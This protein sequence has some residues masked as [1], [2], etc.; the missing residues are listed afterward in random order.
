ME[1][2]KLGIVGA[3]AIGQFNAQEAAQSGVVEIVGVFDTNQK[4]ARSVARKLS[5]PVCA[6][7]EALLAQPN[8][9]AVLLS[10]PHHLHR[11]MTLTAAALGKHILL[12]KPF[13]TTLEEAREIVEGCRRHQV[14]L[15]VNFSL[16][17]LPK[18]RKAKELL[19]QGVVGDIAGFQVVAHA[20][21][22][23][24]YWLGGRSNSPDDWRGSREKAGAGVLFMNVCHAIDYMNMLTGLK[25]SRVYSEYGTLASPAEVEDSASVVCRLSN[26]AIGVINASTIMR[27][28]TQLEER[29]WGQNG[30]LILTPTDLSFYST[31][32]IDGKVP[33]KW[34]TL[35]K[36][37]SVSWTGE[38]VKAFVQALRE[39]REPEVSVRAGW[40][41]LAVIET[42]K[43]AMDKGMPL[44]VPPFPE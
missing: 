24:G 15:S 21:R 37:P 1:S 34:H 35:G 16:R 44:E 19:D 3:G 14:T 42:A 26:G 8:L 22:E 33:G 30:T 27:G 18:I 20:Y 39:G 28:G 9:E 10:V 40:E 31:R 7:Y 25:V 32:P 17:Y 36:F 2:L 41:N 13:A 38:W 12:E 5:S 29:I 43:L 11:D 23:R 6:T 4:V